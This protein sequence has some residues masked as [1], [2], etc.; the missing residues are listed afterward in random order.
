MAE[1]RF[2]KEGFSYRQGQFVRVCVPRLG[3]PEYHPI[4]ISSSPYEDDVTL[5]IR[6]L[7]NW[8]SRLPQL[9]KKEV[10]ILVDGPYGGLTID[11]DL[12]SVVVCFSGGIG[13]TPNRSIARQLLYEHN[14]GK[15]RLDKLR[16]VWTVRSAAMIKALPPP[17]FN[18][19]DELISELEINDGAEEHHSV[20][21]NDIYV[22]KELDGGSE[23]I[24]TPPCTT[25]QPQR[26]DFEAILNEMESE[27]LKRG[28]NRVAVC[29]CGPVAMV[30]E[31]SSLCQKKS[32]CSCG[33]GGEVCF[34]VHEEIFEY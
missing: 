18:E 12:S 2:P 17:T 34:D 11:L 22:T 13:V 27:A 23:R 15:R 32:R 5:T 9:G 24:S 20:L 29:V 26:P 33:S 8:S 7:G 28:L 10:N 25:I 19:R 16:F 1:I 30:K 21:H 4:T 14:N 31:I 3:F 6:S